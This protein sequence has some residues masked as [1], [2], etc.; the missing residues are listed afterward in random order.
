MSLVRKKYMYPSIR[1]A[2]VIAIAFSVLPAFILIVWTSLDHSQYIAENDLE[3]AVRQVEAFAEIQRQMTESTRNLF[4]ALTSLPGFRSGNSQHVQ[5]ML[6]ALLPGNPNYLNLSLTDTKGLV[7]ASPGLPEGTDLSD[8]YH[9]Q[10]VLEEIE[11]L[12]R[13]QT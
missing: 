9:V 2:L 11:A 10:V 13:W 7:T 4:M 5:E 6:A 3:D 8:R 1:L 12:Y